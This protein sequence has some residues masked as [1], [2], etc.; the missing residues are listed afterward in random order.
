VDGP[1]PAGHARGTDRRAVSSTNVFCTIEREPRLS[2]KVADAILETILSH[3]LRPGD[4]LPS[5]RELGRQ[6]GVSRTVIREAIR[7]LDARGM[8]EVRTGSGVRVT[9]VDSSSAR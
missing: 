8:L 9:A 1:K 6:F 4:P 5:E 7:A 3:R 2:D